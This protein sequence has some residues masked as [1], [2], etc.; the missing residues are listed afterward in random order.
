MEEQEGKPCPFELNQVE[1]PELL[2]EVS[3]FLREDFSLSV[4]PAQTWLLS[5]GSGGLFRWNYF[6]RR[7]EKACLP[8]PDRFQPPFLAGIHE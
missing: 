7:A 6:F 5:T 2:L 1:G 3:L 4:C 8:A